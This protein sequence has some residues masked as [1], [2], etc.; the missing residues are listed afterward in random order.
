DSSL[1]IRYAAAEYLAVLD[2][3]GKWIDRPSLADRNNIEVPVEM[4]ARSRRGIAECAD[5]IDSRMNGS[6]LRTIFGGDVA[7]VIA[8]FLELS[9]DP[10]RARA[11]GVAGRIHG[12]NRNQFANKGDNLIGHRVD[13]REDGLL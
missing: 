7:D 12:G 11:I 10:F 5:D 13:T 6:V 3:A 4:E 1:L 2:E 8:K 9:A